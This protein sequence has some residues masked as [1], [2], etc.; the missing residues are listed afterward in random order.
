MYCK[1]SKGDSHTTTSSTAGKFESL[2]SQ[3]QR[4]TGRMSH[5]VDR[6]SKYG[7]PC[8]LSH[9]SEV[10]QSV[11][12]PTFLPFPSKDAYR[13]KKFNKVGLPS[14]T[15]L[16]SHPSIH[17]KTQEEMYFGLPTIFMSALLVLLLVALS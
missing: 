15:P 1:K 14:S 8:I 3:E 5:L 17:K 12:S 4:Y 13:P 6:Q 9:S 10:T 7:L 16:L 11:F 2:A